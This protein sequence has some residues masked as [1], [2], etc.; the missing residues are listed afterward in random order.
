VP[1]TA[2]VSKGAYVTGLA[3]LTADRL[4][5][6][7]RSQT[8]AFFILL[9]LRMDDNWFRHPHSRK[10]DLLSLVIASVSFDSVY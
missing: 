3:D 6:S 1:L 4:S 10:P 8:N 5:F 2:P 9:F 7:S